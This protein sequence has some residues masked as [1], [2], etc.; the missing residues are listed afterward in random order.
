LAPE[1]VSSAWTQ[2]IALASISIEIAISSVWAAKLFVRPE[3]LNSPKNNY[4]R[5]VLQIKFMQL[6]SY[7][8]CILW[9]DVHLQICEG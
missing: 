5:E 2:S 1:H 3:K 9:D 6:E 7:V 4:N 8:H